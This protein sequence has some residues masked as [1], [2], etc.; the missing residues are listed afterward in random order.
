MEPLPSI[1]LTYLANEGFLLRTD[2]DS[3]LIDAFV[4]EPYSIYD[5]LSEEGLEQML[6]LRAPF[7]SID[8]ALVS[9]I[10]RDHFQPE[11][12]LRFLEQAEDCLFATSPDVVDSVSEVPEERTQAF[13]PD[14]GESALLR[15]AGIRVE[16]LRLSHGTG[17]HAAIQNLGHIVTLGGF[18]VL[19]VGDA[20]MDAQNFEPY[21]LAEQDL[22]VAL[23][24]FWY[25][26][27]EKGRE[28]VAEHLHARHV[29]AVHVPSAELDE[30]ARRLR[31]SF[32]EVQLFRECLETRRYSKEKA[33]E[34]R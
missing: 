17:R 2:D 22:D 31:A 5:A 12:A 20:A 33:A 18:K 4:A 1:E 8:L 28:L 24:P 3:V 26:F 9:H 25:F 11:T 10:H 13:L 7:D 32:P 14:P 30:T 23:I 34:P 19:H 15:H 16:F 27:D 21:A 29:V 6:E